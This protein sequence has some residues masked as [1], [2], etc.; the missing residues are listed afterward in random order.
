MARSRA[1]WVMPWDDWRLFA[2]LERN[3]RR[4]VR[5]ARDGERARGRIVGIRVRRQTDNSPDRYEFAV[6][7]LGGAQPFRAGVRQYLVP[8]E[9]LRLGMEVEV[10]HDAEQ[11]TIIDWERTIGAEARDVEL[12]GWKRVDPPADGIDDDTLDGKR[13]ERG[14]RTQAT[15][16]SAGWYSGFFSPLGVN[17]HDLV[18]TVEEEAG[19]R[20]VELGRQTV[21]PYAKHLLREGVVLPVAVDAKKPERVTIDWAAAAVAE[22]GVGVDGPARPEAAQAV[23]SAGPSSVAIETMMAAPVE[24]D[25]VGGIDFNTWVEVSAGLRREKVKPAD[26][27]AYA[28]QHGVAPGT[29]ASA[30]AAWEGR[31]MSDWT[32]GARYGEAFERARKRR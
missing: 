19:P 8:W 26:W 14:T 18:L 23:A 3:R 31:M 25:L 6:E 17:A 32:I 4:A 11:R 5:L 24:E 20:R 10:R 29:W 15:I 21:P 7:V 12:V 1:M 27:D 28:T 2:F 22:P 30:V 9:P 13:L 16:A